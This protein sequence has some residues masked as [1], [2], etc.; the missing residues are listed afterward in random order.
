[1]KIEVSNGEI[2]DKLTILEIK[3]DRIQDPEKI[4]N[5]VKERNAIVRDAGTMLTSVNMDLWKLLKSIN[6]QLWDIE[7]EIRECEENRNFGIRFTQLARQVY[8]TNDER[9]K[10]KKLINNDTNSPLTEEKSY[11]EYSHEETSKRLLRIEEQER[12]K[13]A[14]GFAG[15]TGTSWSPGEKGQ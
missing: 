10:V 9:S 14:T 12:S 7:N 11:K 8:I 6:T 5:I 15:T 13:G 3:L 1:M 4:K 2:V